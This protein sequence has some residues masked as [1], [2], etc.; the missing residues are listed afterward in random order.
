MLLSP[1]QLKKFWSKS[2]GWP[3]LVAARHWAPAEAESERK[4]LLGRAGFTSLTQVDKVDGFSR[5]LHELATLRE[6]LTGM[7]HADANPRRVL[8]HAIQS[9]AKQLSSSWV[10]SCPLGS[11]YLG[12]LMSDRW[13]HMDL[14]RLSLEDLTQLRYTLTARLHSKYKAPRNASAETS[15][16]VS[17]PV[18]DDTTPF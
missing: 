4:A 6:D 17:E 18:T 11:P 5:V 10:G 14:D 7:L 2:D 1:A 12:A 15:D 3:S 8:L 13:G 9:L 16:Q